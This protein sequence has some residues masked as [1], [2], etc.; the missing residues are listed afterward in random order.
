[1]KR[2]VVLLVVGLTQDLISDDTP[3]LAAFAARGGARPLRA[4]LP[5]V[6]CS[7]HAT[8]TTG[9]LPRD[10][11]AVANGWFFRETSEVR[12]WQQSNHLVSGEKI[13]DAARRED[14]S[15]TCAQ[16][17]WWYNMYSGADYTVTPR[18]MYP[19]D[20]RK[21]PDVY[22]QP[23]PLRDELNAKLGT[24]P[25]FNYWGPRAD[26]TTS[27]WIADCAMHIQDTRKPSLSLVYLPHL[28]YNLQRLGPSHPALASDLRAID[29]ICGELIEHAERDGANVVVLSEYG[30]TD[31]RGP[32]HIN[33]ALREAGLIEVRAEMGRDMLDAGASEAFAVADH[34]VAHIYVKRPERIAE[35]RALLERL[36]GVEVVLDADGKRE[37]GL[38]HPR[39]GEL[40]AISAADRW[41]TYYYWLSD[42]RA[43][44]Y[45]RTVDIHRKP[46]YDPVELFM[47]P[48]IRFPMLKV[49][50]ILARRK[51]LGARALL[52]ITPLDASLV[53]GS[54]GRIT[55]D[56]AHGPVFIS[57]DPLLVPE[58]QV[59]ATAV[60]GLLLQQLFG[61]AD[62][63]AGSK[64][65][66]R[67]R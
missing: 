59:D 67:A 25:L 5:A 38:D 14:P 49:G 35:V 23:M 11:G 26:I 61:R 16:L 48:D 7:M 10:H 52:D 63:E 12:L 21:I 53:R 6:T 4:L 50:G 22:T 47:D 57:G 51:L 30:I 3:H 46:G 55:D 45:A 15:F 65:S 56:P 19:A 54:H 36:D 13:W 66:S 64:G 2:T 20:G 24:F 32:V 44:D 39:S 17:F 33:R 40:V 8:F 18:P 29:A 34:Q 41:F 42:D 58:G 1:V 9:L 37:N 31:V 60:K 27:R 28:D 62:I 43:P